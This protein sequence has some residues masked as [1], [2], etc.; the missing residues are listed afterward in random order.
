MTIVYEKKVWVSKANIPSEGA[1]DI[2]VAVEA[3]TEE[4]AKKVIEE[5]LGGTVIDIHGPYFMQ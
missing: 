2:N 3:E 5:K 1:D 4:E